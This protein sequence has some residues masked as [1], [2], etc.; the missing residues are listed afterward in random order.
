M[1]DQAGVDLPGQASSQRL[2]RSAPLTGGRRSIFL[3]LLSFRSIAL[4]CDR[5]LVRFLMAA[6]AA[7]LCFRWNNYGE[8][9]IAAEPGFGGWLSIIGAILITSHFSSW[10]P[11]LKSIR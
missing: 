6:V 10:L 4:D 5:R 11:S 9:Y 1:S 3:I 2:G 8:R 7:A